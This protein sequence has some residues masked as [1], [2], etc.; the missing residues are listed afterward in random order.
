[1]IG[2]YEEETR[3]P[4]K[5][6]SQSNSRTRTLLPANHHRP[7]K[8]RTMSVNLHFFHTKKTIKKTGINFTF[9]RLIFALHRA[10]TRT[11]RWTGVWERNSS[12]SG[13]ENEYKKEGKNVKNSTSI[14]IEYNYIKWFAYKKGTKRMHE[15][16]YEWNFFILRFLRYS[17]SLVLARFYYIY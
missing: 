13:E 7:T 2:N 16:F 14:P 11:Q 12:K 1:M 10:Q 4:L 3:S 8:T 5:I 9:I 6:P 17:F 15:T